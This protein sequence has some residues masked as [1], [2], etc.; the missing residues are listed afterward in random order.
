M[1]NIKSFFAYFLFKESRSAL[2]VLV[3]RFQLDQ[4]GAVF[5]QLHAINVY[6]VVVAVLHKYEITA[7]SGQHTGGQLLRP[8]RLQACFLAYLRIKV[9]VKIRIEAAGQVMLI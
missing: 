2:V 9:I 5:L 1:E 4:T 3:H 8:G 7:A 6:A